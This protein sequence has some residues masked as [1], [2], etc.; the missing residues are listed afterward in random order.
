MPVTNVVLGVAV[1]ITYIVTDVI[2]DGTE[3][4]YLALMGAGTAISG[5]AGILMAEYKGAA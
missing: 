1:G 3:Q 2:A 4:F 5:S